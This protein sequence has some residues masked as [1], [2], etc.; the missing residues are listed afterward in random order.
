VR[1]SKEG[2]TACREKKNVG[3]QKG[4]KKR[5]GNSDLDEENNPPLAGKRKRKGKH[6][7]GKG[8]ENKRREGR[9]RDLIFR[10]DETKE[11]CY[12]P[13][14]RGGVRTLPPTKE[15]KISALAKI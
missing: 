9:K 5:D 4:E 13:G 7:G 8:G 6:H 15:G 3:E 14:G 11:L 1:V 10:L 12:L 2:A